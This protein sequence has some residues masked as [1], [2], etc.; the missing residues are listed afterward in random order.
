MS[1]AHDHPEEAVTGGDKAEGKVPPPSFREVE[2]QN[3]RNK[4]DGL[5]GFPCP[6]WSYD[7]VMTRQPYFKENYVKRLDRRKFIRF[8]WHFFGGSANIKLQ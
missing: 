2:E 4:C 7:N 1:E 6:S 5:K 8:F 3:D